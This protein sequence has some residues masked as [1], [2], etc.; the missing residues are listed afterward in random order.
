MKV[1]K[2][3][4]FVALSSLLFSVL[5]ACGS[6]GGGSSG[7][8]TIEGT[9]RH[10]NATS[11][12][13]SAGEGGIGGVEVSALGS[14]AITDE[15]GNFRLSVDG[16]TFAGGDVFFVFTG[17]GI[18]TSV[19]LEGVT[20][21]VDQ[22]AFTDFVREASGNISGESFDAA[23]NLLGTTPG[24][25][26][27]CSVVNTFSDGALGALWKPHSERT[28]TVVVLMPPNYASAGVAIYNSRGEVV[29]GPVLRNCCDHNGG[30]EH[31][32]F[33]RT[34]SDLAGAGVPLT[35]KFEFPDGFADCRTVPNPNQ[36][37]D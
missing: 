22:V 7:S 11:R 8:L 9:L 32:Y 34:A 37:Y 18:D 14:S 5:L 1:G 12:V 35:V 4:F 28:G 25:R 21:G 15:L 10:A 30:R 36:R 13:L 31:V 24:G 27:N 20:G 19:V 17:Q 26:L 29:D 16:E 6:S 23:G 33:S 3:I 2:S